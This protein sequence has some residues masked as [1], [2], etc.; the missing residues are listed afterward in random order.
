MEY[1]G[2]DPTIGIKPLHTMTLEQATKE[3]EAL[4]LELAS[5]SDELPKQHL[6]TFRKKSGQADT[7][8]SE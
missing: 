4:G 1:R 6:M 2:E 7:L 3:M 8:N 5:V